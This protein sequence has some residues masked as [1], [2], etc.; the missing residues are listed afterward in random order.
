VRF[1]WMFGLAF[2]DLLLVFDGRY[3]D[4]PLGLFWPPAVG[5]LLAALMETRGNCVVPII[6]ER[7]MACVLPL[8]AAVVVAQEIG[9]N[10]STWLWLAVNFATAGAVM[11]EWRRALRLHTHQPQ[12]AYQ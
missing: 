5:F 7:F 4:F 9:L 11:I 6:E 1:L 12:A 8:L 3:R 2:Y 10:P